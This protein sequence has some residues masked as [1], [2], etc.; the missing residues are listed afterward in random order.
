M[1]DCVEN[2]NRLIQATLQTS[3]TARVLLDAIKIASAGKE[4]VEIECVRCEDDSKHVAIYDRSGERPSVHLVI[5][6]NN[7]SI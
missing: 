3:E 1:S 7:V 2:C 4:K 5:H 6:A